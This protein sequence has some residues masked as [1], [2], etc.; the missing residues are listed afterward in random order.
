MGKREI[1]PESRVF[2][3]ESVIAW[4]TFIVQNQHCILPRLTR[5]IAKKTSAEGFTH[6]VIKSDCCEK[7][8]RT[9]ATTNP[10]GIPKRYVNLEKLFR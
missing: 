4:G 8:D 9:P 7:S 3:S 6:T 5:F 10:Y 2:G 1:N